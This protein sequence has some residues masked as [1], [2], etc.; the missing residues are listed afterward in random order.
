MGDFEQDTHVHKAGNGYR[1]RLSEHW[2]IWGPN[3]GYVAAIA[4]RAAGEAAAL[5]RPVTFQGHYLRAGSFAAVD[6]EVTKVQGGRRAESLDVTMTQEGKPIFKGLLRTSAIGDGLSYDE[7]RETTDGTRVIPRPETLPL[8]DENRNKYGAHAFWK[9]FERRVIH[10]EYLVDHCRTRWARREEWLRFKTDSIFS[11]PFVDAGRAMVLLDTF[12]WPAVYRKMGD[13]NFIAPSLDI[14]VFFHQQAAQSRWLRVD[15]QGPFAQDGLI[16]GQ[17]RVFDEQ[18][19]T[20]ASGYSHLMCV[21]EP[22]ERMA[23]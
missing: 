3:G 13:C 10:P 16:A 12:M 7:I 8:Y 17:G 11:D 6:I 15:A 21:S 2:E 14:T 19:R 1:A 23:S 9:N 4:L 22:T 18:G 5:K 20:I